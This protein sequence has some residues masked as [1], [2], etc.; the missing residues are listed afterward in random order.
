MKQQITR[1][2]INVAIQDSWIEFYDL[3]GMYPVVD[4]SPRLGSTDDLIVEGAWRDNGKRI[5]SVAF[6][7]KLITGDKHDWPIH[8]GAIPVVYAVAFNDGPHVS[9][10]GVS[11]GYQTVVFWEEF[12]EGG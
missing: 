1:N 2:Q 5:T 9:Y 4:V 8:A 11:R 6:R 3:D 10:H 12:L 7:R